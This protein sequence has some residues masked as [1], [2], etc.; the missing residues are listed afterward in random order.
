MYEILKKNSNKGKKQKEP[1]SSFTITKKSESI[2]INC[3]VCSFWIV[4]DWCYSSKC[5]G[6]QRD[7]PQSTIRNNK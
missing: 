3:G 4:I 1:K 5:D 7:P 2:S 6:S